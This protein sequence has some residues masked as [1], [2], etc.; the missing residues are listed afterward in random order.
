MT[1]CHWSGFIRMTSVSLVMPALLTSTSTV[2]QC[3]TDSFTNLQ[4]SH[5][6]KPLLCRTGLHVDHTLCSCGNVLENL[7]SPSGFHIN[8]LGSHSNHALQ[9]SCNP[10]RCNAPIA[11]QKVILFVPVRLVEPFSIHQLGTQ[12]HS[13]CQLHQAWICQHQW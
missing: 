9:R 3:D 4:D 10:E 13:T 6:I 2:P 1:D 7:D 12:E 5:W 11:G 8:Q